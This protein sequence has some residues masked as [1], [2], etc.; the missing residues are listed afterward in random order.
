MLIV[1]YTV[2][3]CHFVLEIYLLTL[4]FLLVLRVWQINFAFYVHSVIYPVLYAI[5]CVSVSNF[6]MFSQCTVQEIVTLRY[7]NAIGE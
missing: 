2:I 4:S 5:Y 3:N 1:N 7:N 6:R